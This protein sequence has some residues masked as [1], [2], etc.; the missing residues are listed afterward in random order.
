MKTLALLAAVLMCS[1][2]GRATF[3]INP[4]ALGVDDDTRQAVD[5][6]GQASNYRAPLEVSPEGDVE[7]VLV[8]AEEGADLCGKTHTPFSV[9]GEAGKIEIFDP[10]PPSCPPVEMRWVTIAHELGHLMGQPKHSPYPEDLM[11]GEYTGQDWIT[12]RDVTFVLGEP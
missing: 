1:A 9:D 6:W 8:P 10:P 12:A 11:F 7:V 3:R 2:C 4:T 5:A